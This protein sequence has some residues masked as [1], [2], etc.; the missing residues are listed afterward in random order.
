MHTQMLEDKEDDFDVT[1][2]DTWTKAF[3]RSWDVIQEDSFGQIFL[4]H[5][6]DQIQR[7]ARMKS[8]LISEKRIEKGFLRYL[9]II[10][11]CSESML[12]KKD[13]KPN[14]MI[15]T[16]KVVQKFII[17]YFDQNPLSQMGII[18]AHHKIAQKMADLG[19]NPLQQIQRLE[20]MTD[21]VYN[22]ESAH[23]QEHENGNESKSVNNL[24][25]IQ[26]ALKL[27]QKCLSQ[28]PVHGS[29]ELIFITSALS[30]IDP[31]IIYETIEE[32][33]TN[34]IRTDIISLSAELRILRYICHQTQGTFN[35]ILNESHF[36]QVLLAKVSPQPVINNNEYSAKYRSREW[37]QMGFPSLQKKNYPSLCVCHK[38]QW[39]YSGYYCPKCTA[40]VCELPTDCTLCGL[41]LISSPHLVRSYHHIF[42]VP[43]F[44][45]METNDEQKS[46]EE[47]ENDHILDSN[48]NLCFGCQELINCKQQLM[49]RCQKCQQCF[50][51]EC[52]VFIHESLH[53]CPGCMSFTTT[54]AV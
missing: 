50:C 27:G 30:T 42:P 51:V 6:S 36:E 23:A 20:N 5:K 33:K 47:D 24:L 2:E 52:N 16:Q 32:L 31:S 25:S 12:N 14:R 26:N 9:F 29:R 49:E 44:T 40:K 34:K 13:L 15:V 19:G 43:L 48:V 37:I 38:K 8:H 21:V 11:D 22:Y 3:D 18:V 4:D 1:Q 53:N 39:T 54:L 46:M 17:Q 41:A 10:I 7:I 28:I 35:V 45:E